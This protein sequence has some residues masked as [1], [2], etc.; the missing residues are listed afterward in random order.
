[1]NNFR[2]LAQSK[3]RIRDKFFDK[4]EPNYIFKNKSLEALVQYHPTKTI[5]E[6]EYFVYR[7]KGQGKKI[8]FMKTVGYDESTIGLNTCLENY[9]DRY[10]ER[11]T[12]LINIKYAFREAISNGK[13]ETYLRENTTDGI[14][15]CEH[16]KAKT[17]MAI[18]HYPLSFKKI[19]ADFLLREGLKLE[20]LEYIRC[21]EDNIIKLKDLELKSKWI[22][23]HE[24]LVSYRC[25]C[26]SCN[27]KFGC[28]GQ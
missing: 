1:M 14:G 26:K 19:L 11:K 21:M 28:Y 17:F 22:D 25:L 16:C 23:Y 6:V 12:F 15:I 4:I 13:R 24:N 9:F 18:D 8:L 7:I 10:D 5:N 3:K 2:N 20:D 27:S